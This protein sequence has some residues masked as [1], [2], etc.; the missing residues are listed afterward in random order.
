MCEI[1]SGMYS[2]Q[3]FLYGARFSDVIFVMLTVRNAHSYTHNQPRNTVAL[4][5]GVSQVDGC[6]VSC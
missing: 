3:M 5:C 2:N 1:L 6:V 4:S